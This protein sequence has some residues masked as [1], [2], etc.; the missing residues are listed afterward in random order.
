MAPEW[1]RVMLLPIGCPWVQRITHLSKV[2][3]TGMKQPKAFHLSQ[4]WAP[5]LAGGRLHQALQD[6]VQDLLKST[7]TFSSD[8]DQT[9]F[10]KLNYKLEV[11]NQSHGFLKHI[12]HVDFQDAIHYERLLYGTREMAQWLRAPTAVSE[13]LSSVTRTDITTHETPIPRYI[14]SLTSQQALDI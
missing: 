3:L 13:D 11:T 4:T 12:F 7:W 5:L 10:Q 8:F 6:Q 9:L 14:S 1:L 2:K